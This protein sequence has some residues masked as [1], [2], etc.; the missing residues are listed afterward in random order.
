M[1]VKKNVLQMDQ[2]V[3]SGKIVEAVRQFFDDSAVTSDYNGVKTT[4][5]AQMLEKM[6][7]FVDAIGSVNGISH[8]HTVVEGRV[9]ASEF[10]FD[11]VMKDGSNLYWHEVIRRIWNDEGYVV[12]EEYF[13]AKQV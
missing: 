11:F 10:T 8:H 13:D 2:L 5:K 4:T 12:A 3:T 9:S 1:D 7:G 6:H